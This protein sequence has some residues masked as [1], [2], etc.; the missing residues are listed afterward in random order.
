MSFVMARSE[1][2][3]ASAL[4]FRNCEHI[5]I[6]KAENPNFLF[7]PAK[8]TELYLESLISYTTAS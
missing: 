3:F 4:Y 2:V 6:T 7:P 8:L 5:G 1:G